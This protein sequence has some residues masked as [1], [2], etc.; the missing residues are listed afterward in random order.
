M[1]EL[2]K[3]LEG[4]GLESVPQEPNTYPELNP[5]DIYRSH[6]TELL[7]E[8]SGVDK[9]IIYPTLAW[10]AKPENGDLQLAVPALRLKGKDLKAY[11]QE[12]AEKFPESPLVKK[13]VV[14]G[15]FVG[16]FF[17]PES[18]ISIVL[19]LIFKAG[20]SYGF[21]NSFG[22]KEDGSKK[23][24]VID[25]SSPNIAKPFHAGHL[26]STIIG[27]FLS[28]L[29]EGMGW[30]V[31]RLNYLGDWGKQYG[32]LAIGFDYFGSEEELV[33]NPIGHLYDIYVKVSNIQKDEADK[34]KA[35][36]A[37]VTK[38]KEEGKDTSAKEAEIT[39]IETE[40]IDEK[41]RQY[42]K[43]MV[44][45]EP[46]A[47][48]IWKRFRVSTLVRALLRGKLIKTGTIHREVQA[49]LCSPEHSLRCLQWRVAG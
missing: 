15:T 6:I 37:E 8:V 1:E 18:L 34:A 24:M 7:A 27:G 22:L 4:L 31:V 20:K 12:L 30:E 46:K 38:D 10:T 29:Y 21:N 35:L 28:N 41:A 19:P 42:F 39:K 43:G 17:K 13:P 3:T 36:K 45:G 23:K 40:G 48:G 32:V 47:I 25:F 2:T 44:D 9:K 5:F 11:A 49:D 16:F 26:R 14:T 33:K